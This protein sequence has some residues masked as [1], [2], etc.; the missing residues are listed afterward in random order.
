MRALRYVRHAGRGQLQRSPLY[1]Q[2]ST[3][4]TLKSLGKDIC[5]R[6][7]SRDRGEVGAIVVG[8]DSSDGAT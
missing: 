5:R 2:T 3:K 6:A 4:L 8:A 1:V 7:M